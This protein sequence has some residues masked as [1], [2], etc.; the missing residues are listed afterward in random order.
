[1]T[2]C[3]F[4][5]LAG[6]I[7]QV[8]DGFPQQQQLEQIEA[9][10]TDELGEMGASALLPCYIKPQLGRD[11]C[12]DWACER[13]PKTRCYPDE[14]GMCIFQYGFTQYCGG[15]ECGRDRREH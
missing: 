3:T 11:D 6:E 1:M 13:A 4:F 8:N 12:Q 10:Q 7:A 15:C 9:I 2:I 5:A 14:Q